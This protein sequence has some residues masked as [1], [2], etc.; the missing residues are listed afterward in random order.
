MSYEYD[1]FI[2]YRR[3]K[4]WSGWVY[5]KFLDI[6]RHYV[7]EEL[8]RDI[9]IFIDQ[10]IE[11]GIH[12]PSQL[13]FAHSKSKILVPLLSN[14]YFSSSWCLKE[15]SLMRSREL[16]SEI[17]NAENT[18]GLIVPAII[19][20]CFN[21]PDGV[22][23]IQCKDLKDSTNVMMCTDSP[24]GERLALEILSWAPDVASAINN[25]PSYQSDWTELASIEFEEVFRMSV[26]QNRLPRI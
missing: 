12:W 5:E 8:G 26:K 9:S 11:S 14:Q 2:S 17:C 15:I 18:R 6:F 1:V 16:A 22:R 24:I 19:S 7:G 3:S 21:L 23:D 25:A 13:A 4:L 10:E 20:G